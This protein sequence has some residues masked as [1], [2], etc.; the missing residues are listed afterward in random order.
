MAGQSPLQYA[1]RFGVE[2][3]GGSGG[4]FGYAYD[5]GEGSAADDLDG[6]DFP[7]E[8]PDPSEPPVK[9]RRGLFGRK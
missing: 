3:P 9:K 4:K 2:R 8:G 6:W 1:D 5:F 7:P